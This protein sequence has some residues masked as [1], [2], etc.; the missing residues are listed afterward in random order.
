M[1]DGKFIEDFTGSGITPY[2]ERKNLVDKL[3]VGVPAGSLNDPVRGS[4]KDRLAKGFLYLCDYGTDSSSKPVS[5]NDP[6]IY[7]VLIRPQLAFPYLRDG[8]LDA[9][10]AGD[11]WYYEWLTRESNIKKDELVEKIC[12]LNFGGVGLVPATK[13][14]VPGNTMDEFLEFMIQR[15]VK[16]LVGS[17]EYPGL[18]VELLMYHVLRNDRFREYFGEG[19][20]TVRF[21]S[22]ETYKS[23]P[24]LRIEESCGAT[25]AQVGFTSHW[26][27]E[28]TQK[29]DSFASHYLKPLKSE[30]NI[31]SSAG[32]YASKS[33]LGTPHKQKK[34]YHFRDMLERF[35]DDVIDPRNLVVLEFDTTGI[36]NLESVLRAYDYVNNVCVN[37]N[38]VKFETKARYIWTIAE[39]LR[40]HNVGLNMLEVSR[41][42]K[43]RL[44]D[45]GRRRRRIL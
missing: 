10:I 43:F 19:R 26:I 41:R 4:T 25:E 11:D 34:I 28:V 35:G 22:G 17:S 36:E 31:S 33:A 39:M 5:V 8:H 1:V 42:K 45:F 13:K 24:K 30:N 9:A 23:N 7:P 3:V 27:L 15:G 37:D 21:V 6:D 12:D 40:D 14:F 29:G 44:F 38:S 18:A 20:P 2:T 32:F 16:E